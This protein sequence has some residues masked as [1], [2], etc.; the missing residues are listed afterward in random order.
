MKFIVSSLTLS[1]QLQSIVGVIKSKNTLPILDNFL[2]DVQDNELTIC[3]TDLETSIKAK[4]SVE[5]TESGKLCIPARKL[6][7]FLKTFAELPLTF[8]LDTD[9][10][11][12]TISSDAG[13][14]VLPG[15]NPEDFPK[16]PQIESE[17]T[18][19]IPALGLY[20]GISKTLFAAGQDEMRP[21]MTGVFIELNENSATFVATDAHKLVKYERKDVKT[22]EEFSSIIVPQKPLIVLK[23]LLLIDEE[24]NIKVQYDST[25]VHFIFNNIELAGK[26]IEG[27]YPNYQAV[28][29]QDNPSI[30]TA[31]RA[32]LL[33]S[34]KRI[35]QFA[36]KATYQCKF[37]ITGS[38]LQISSQDLDAATDAKERMDCSYEGE[39]MN[40]G[41]NAKFLSEMLS[42]IED[43][44]I[45]I[46]LSH[47]SK[48]GILEPFNPDDNETLLML[49]MP[50][51]V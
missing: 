29:P 24:A 45:N 25:N 23:N 49:L 9:N 26:L 40:I 4:V 13:K 34:I 15:Y 39:D 33:S 28:I 37:A 38:E 2:F 11:E 36:N 48:A 12:V 7:D 27:K 16:F 5:C 32:S 20:S 3:A 30:L 6:I 41:F 21:I 46:K 22:S 1:K 51:A 31:D 44:Q 42:N 43:E 35:L 14:Y 19:D 17:M 50:V 8:D 10:L 18:F 47:P